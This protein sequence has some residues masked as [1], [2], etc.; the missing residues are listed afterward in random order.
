MSEARLSIRFLVC[1][2]AAG[3]AVLARAG[4][5]AAHN[6]RCDRAT[7]GCHGHRIGLYQAGG[8]IAVQ[9]RSHAVLKPAEADRDAESGVAAFGICVG[10]GAL[11]RQTRR[12]Y[13]EIAIY[14]D[15]TGTRLDFT[16][17]LV[18]R[19]C[20]RHRAGDRFAVATGLRARL[21]ERGHLVVGSRSKG[22]VVGCSDAG[23]AIH[24][25][26]RSVIGDVDAKRQAHAEALA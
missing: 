23:P 3:L 16:G 13:G 26:R 14:F 6:R 1:G 5:T 4:R 17:R 8:H 10:F 24:A 18:Q 2:G 7:S 25:R 12:R 9:L 11:L 21:C 20:Y 15:N 22:D 19:D